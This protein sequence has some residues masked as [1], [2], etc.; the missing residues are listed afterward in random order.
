MVYPLPSRPSAP[1]ASRLGS[2]DASP[3]VRARTSSHNLRSAASCA[4]RARRS[5][6]R[7]D[8]R[9]AKRS[10]QRCFSRAC[11]CRPR[12]SMPRAAACKRT[13]A[14][15]S[16]TSA[17]R[18][19]RTRAPRAA[20]CRSVHERA[21]SVTILRCLG[22]ATA[23]R[24]TCSRL[25]DSRSGVGWLWLRRVS[26]GCRL[27][28]SIPRAAAW[29]RVAAR[30]RRWCS[31]LRNAFRYRVHSA[32]SFASVAFWACRSS[33]RMWSACHA[34][35]GTSRV[36]PFGQARCG[37]GAWAR[38]APLHELATFSLPV[39]GSAMAGKPAWLFIPR[40]DVDVDVHVHVHVRAH[41]RVT[42]CQMLSAGWNPASR[43]RRA[44]LTVSRKYVPHI[45]PLPRS[46][47]ISSA[48]KLDGV[49]VWMSA[50]SVH[51]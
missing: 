4:F 42:S 50:F 26:R 37:A 21:S 28:E 15:L 36:V 25:G 24:D 46:F 6:C 22:A 38:V 29:S 11:A 27:R 5:C 23:A 49:S 14:L 10:D 40:H 30:S 8:S 12:E 39:I 16:A 45:G 35:A 44:L 19:A 18:R 47:Q 31:N 2:T 33:T 43:R 13:A 7:A 32:C 1:G 17:A 34:A 41:A 9:L 51:R 48:G 20:A 3:A